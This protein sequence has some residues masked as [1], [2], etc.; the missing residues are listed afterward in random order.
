MKILL[1]EDGLELSKFLSKQHQCHTAKYEEIYTSEIASSNY[2]LL[3]LDFK[4]EIFSLIREIRLEKIAIPILV[5]SNAT[6]NRDALIEKISALSIGA[7]DAIVAPIDD[8]ELS[9][10]I[11]ALIRRSA[12]NS[13]NVI[14]IGKLSLDLYSQLVFVSGIPL[15]LTRKEYSILE[16]LLLKKNK[17][18]T[19]D[20]IMDYLYNGR[21]EPEI[22]ILDVFMTK[23]RKKIAL[24]SNGD[25]YITTV[26]G[27]GYMILEKL[28]S[29]P[30][31]PIPFTSSPFPD[32]TNA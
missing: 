22:K 21:D 30:S 3:I 27:R 13:H 14:S 17:V 1:I 6:D 29:P 15:P 8:R 16:L 4:K 5:I 7:D 18:Q 31:P 28:A 20:S 32:N 12:G 9:A 11:I 25:D 23:I 24:L 10:R 26:W 19:K 2:D